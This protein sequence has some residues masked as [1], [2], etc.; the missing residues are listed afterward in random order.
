MW[1][2]IIF[3]LSVA[4]V[5]AL[6]VEL[7][8]TMEIICIDPEAT[9]YATFQSHN[10]KVVS[11][12]FGL[13]ESHI[14]TRNEAYTAQQWRLSRS[15]DG[16]RTFTTVFQDTYATNPPPI[17]TDAAGN[18]YLASVDWNNGNA[19]LYRFLTAK[20][21][22]DPDITIIPNGA[23]GKYALALDEPRGQLYFFSNNG[24]LYVIGMD[25]T[26]RDS[27]QLLR[28]G[29][30]AYLMYPHLCLDADGTL[31]AGWTSQQH[32]VYLYWDIHH[33]L[34]RDGSATWR[35]VR[36][37]ELTLPV[38][39]DDTGPALRLT[40]DSEFTVHTFLANMLAHAGK[41]HFT[42]MVQTTPS[43]QQYA[44]YDLATG[45]RDAEFFPVFSGETIALKGL[46]GFFASR[47]ADAKAPLYCVASAGGRI[48]CLESIDN[49]ATWHDYALSEA[50]FNPYAIGGSREISA[51]GYIYGT[52]IDQVVPTAE[53]TPQTK[54]YLVKI[55]AR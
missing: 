31:H 23:G 14:R 42:Y 15:T 35:D 49:G 30:H 51:D 1:C 41:L 10:Q 47:A 25:G 55:K 54:V 44:R 12:P 38:I 28:D 19:Y 2:L 53:L 50:T 5:G 24:S 27:R 32:G 52:F 39:S 13:F 17:E 20:A 29:P 11:N 3:A 16:G 7:P 33:I 6:A 18:L 45:A 43:G 36:G 9:G 37:A 21:F 22:R 48:G 4:C 40:R 8:G 46:D 26:L 34:S